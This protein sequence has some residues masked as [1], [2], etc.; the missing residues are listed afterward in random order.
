VNAVSLWADPAA[1]QHRRSAEACVICRQGM[2]NDILAEL[3]TSWVTVNEDAPMRGYACLVLRRH[4]VE[5]H[6]LTEAEGAAFMRDVRRVSAAV[7]AV[8]A[9][10]KL[11]YEVHGNSIP[12]LHMH[13]LPRYPGDPF[14]G[15][16]I[17]PKAVSQPVYAPGEVATFRARLRAALDDA[18]GGVR[19]P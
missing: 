11:N 12:H 14:E 8:T 7:Q 19:S 13:F 3:E 17:D 16:P 6:D 5:L 15:G 4:A 1:W 10:I 9:A 18:A 2:P